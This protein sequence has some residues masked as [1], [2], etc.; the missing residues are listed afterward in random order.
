ML[1]VHKCHG[2]PTAKIYKIVLDLVQKKLKEARDEMEGNLGIGLY[3]MNR[4]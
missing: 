1:A 4:N 2:L 3:L